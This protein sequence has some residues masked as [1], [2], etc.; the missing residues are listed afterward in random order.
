MSNN[1]TIQSSPAT[2]QQVQA[3]LTTPEGKAQNLDVRIEGSSIIMPKETLAKLPGELFSTVFG[4][5]LAPANQQSP[6]AIQSAGNK[7]VS[8]AEGD[9]KFEIASI[10]T[11]LAKLAIEQ[12]K[13]GKEA[14]LQALDNRVAE[15]DKQVGEMKKAADKRFIGAMINGAITIAANAKA[16]RGY[17]KINT[18]ANPG[19]VQHQTQTTVA[20]TQ[21]AQNVGQMA[22][23]YMEHQ[24]AGHDR[25]AKR[26]EKNAEVQQH[27]MEE[28]NAFA[29]SAKEF[30]S[31]IAQKLSGIQQ[32]EAE[33]MRTIT[34]A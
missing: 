29:N 30:F 11:L 9:G 23:A 16:V 27:H 33:T 15:I 10:L 28:M 34:R 3:Y 19:L 18:N 13:M 4:N 22:N 7:F 24:A 26:H 2:L 6:G 12:R 21:I 5:V 1:V 14:R 20:R 25:D 17:A 32:A 31:D 8:I